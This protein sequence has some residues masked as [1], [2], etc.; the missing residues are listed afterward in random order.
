LKKRDRHR[1][2]NTS[3]TYI[4]GLIG[5]LTDEVKVKFEAAEEYLKEI[6]HTPINPLKI[7]TYRL[8]IWPD[9]LLVLADCHSIFLL[10]DWLQSEESR[11]EKYYCEVTGKDIIF[12]SRMENDHYAGAK[13]EYE[14]N[15][16]SGAIHEVTGMSL[17]DYADGPRT[18]PKYFCRVLFSIQC[19]RGGIDPEDIA[20]RYIQRDRTTILHYLKKYPDELKFNPKFREIAE[21]VNQK[22]CSETCQCDTTKL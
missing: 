18:E 17:E 21:K 14:V 6:N 20:F 9:R 1:V 8:A 7:N 13:I 16:I 5:T 15:R 12:Q 22:L 11:M 3:T 19:K 4:S 2:M 10:S